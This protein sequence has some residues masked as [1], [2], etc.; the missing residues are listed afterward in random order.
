MQPRVN[1]YITDMTKN[2]KYIV[3]QTATIYNLYVYL[4]KLIIRLILWNI[5]ILIVSY[6]IIFLVVYKM[7]NKTKG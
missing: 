3:V 1:T 2:S 4:A 6:I 5:K 7:G